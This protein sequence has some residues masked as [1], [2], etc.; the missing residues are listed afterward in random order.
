[1]VWIFIVGIILVLLIIIA[2]LYHI[3][4]SIKNDYNNKLSILV[5]QI[6]SSQYYD[7]KFD[8]K[9][10]FSIKKLQE[11]LDKIQ[12]TYATKTELTNQISNINTNSIQS[13]KIQIGKNA[14]ITKDGSI[15]GTK[16]NSDAIQSKSI[17]SGDINSDGILT[18][19]LCLDNVCVTKDDLYRLSHPPVNCVVSGWS[20]WTKCD[21]LC[22]GGSQTRTRFVTTK[23]ANGGTEC[24]ALTE[25][26]KCNTQ[27]C[28]QDCKVSNWSGWEACSKT[29]GGGVQTRTRTIIQPRIN[30]GTECPTLYED[31]VCNTNPCPLDCMVSVWSDWSKCDKPCEGG[32]QTRTRTVLQQAAYNGEKCPILN[33]SQICNTQVCP[34]DC[35]VSAWSDWSTCANN[36]QTRTR[37]ITKQA[38]NNG[39]AC[40]VLTES[41]S[42]TVQPLA[43]N[44]NNTVNFTS[45]T[46]TNAGATG[47]SGPTLAQCKAAYSAAAWTQDINN[48]NMTT[49][50]IQL[51]KVPAS[52]SYTIICVGAKGGTGASVGG[53]GATIVSTF[54][55]TKG[56]IYAICI[57]QSG[58][59]GNNQNN[60][61]TDCGGGGGASVIYL[62]GSKTPLMIAG[63]GGG[64]GGTWVG[65][66][67]VSGA[68]ASVSINPNQST[69]GGNQASL[70]SGG[71]GGSTQNGD[72]TYGAG[73]G[74]GWYT[75]GVGGG[76]GSTNGKALS[77]IP[78]EGGIKGDTS[79]DGGFGGGGGGRN[80]IAGGGGGY[81]GGN[82]GWDSG[83]ITGGGGGSSYSAGSIISSSVTNSDNGYIKITLN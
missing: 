2:T 42:C 82:C 18:K 13:D 78:P 65:R 59:N 81:N 49:Q 9:D 17:R 54:N 1:M 76:N 69:G 57:G 45:F 33:E 3:I 63:G 64:G 53:N 41:Q 48:F 61:Y 72:K 60:A 26:Q 35:L 51:W 23:P 5:D 77:Q 50:G 58:L 52:G 79:G 34:T 15:S 10:K 67:T 31:Q 22:G 56:D 7:Y 19:S 75:D 43:N 40:P 68:S 37:T 27:P 46:F 70:A 32:S 21:K 38:S 44:A 4:K 28:A 55:L 6:N 66:S 12:K 8:K 16:L 80:V 29:C 30:D 71:N 62:V 83:I 11:I 47:R 14:Y 36:T 39:A 24:P 73:A 20:E 25:L 74:G